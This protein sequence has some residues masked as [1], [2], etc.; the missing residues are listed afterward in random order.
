[1]T[2]SD[3]HAL[4]RRHAD[5]A[6][7]GAGIVGLCLAGFLAQ[8]G[9]DVM[10]IDAGGSAASTANAGSLHVQMQ[11]RFMR[12]FPER[13]AGFEQQLPLTYGIPLGHL[14]LT[15]I[16]CRIKLKLLVFIQHER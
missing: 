15:T 7:I 4:P 3:T 5:V 16:L 2:A 1:M 10:L 11:S 13:V 14:F 8:S 9:R 6:V 12:L